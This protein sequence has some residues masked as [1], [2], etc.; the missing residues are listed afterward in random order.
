MDKFLKRGLF[1][2]LA[3]V[4]LMPLALLFKNTNANITLAV[5][6]LS[7]ILEL[8]GLVFVVISV[9]KQRRSKKSIS[10]DQKSEA[11]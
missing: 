4:F 8:I 7:M 2:M 9:L 11:N 10:Y 1:C 5:L 3:A 6:F